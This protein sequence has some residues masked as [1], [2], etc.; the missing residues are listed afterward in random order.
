MMNILINFL[1]K[2]VSFY[3]FPRIRW[4]IWVLKIRLTSRNDWTTTSFMWTHVSI[5]SISV[6]MKAHYSFINTEVLLHFIQLCSWNFFFITKSWFMT[7]LTTIVTN[8][9]FLVKLRFSLN[10]WIKGLEI[11]NIWKICYLF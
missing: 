3:Y 11:L 10:F 4:W 8:N 2:I 7:I 5:V 9:W 1:F 6:T